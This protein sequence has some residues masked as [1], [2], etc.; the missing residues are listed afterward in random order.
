M[1][2]CTLFAYNYAY[3]G[4]LGAPPLAPF[5]AA[6]AAFANSVGGQRALMEN[7]M[8]KANANSAAINAETL[9][10]NARAKYAVQNG[11]LMNTQP[12]RPVKPAGLLKKGLNGLFG[13]LPKLW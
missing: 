11:L 5:D 2:V 3:S 4:Y 6:T 9:A 8:A 12:I 10:A 1:C 13:G 7:A